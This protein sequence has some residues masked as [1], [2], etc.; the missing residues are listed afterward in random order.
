M[1]IRKSATVY[2]ALLE[3]MDSRGLTKNLAIDS[4]KETL[5]TKPMK[6]PTHS[7]KTAAATTY[8]KL[9]GDLGKEGES[10]SKPSFLSFSEEEFDEMKQTHIKKTITISQ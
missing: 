5:E 6:K 7:E 2:N 1:T 10:D 8:F 4:L 9:S 3:L